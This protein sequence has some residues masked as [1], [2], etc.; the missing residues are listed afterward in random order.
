MKLLHLSAIG[1][2]D[3]ILA[4]GILP[5]KISLES[6]LWAF[7]DAGLNGD[8]CVYTWDSEQGQSTDKYIR[9]MIYCK[10]FIHPRNNFGLE[11]YEKLKEQGIHSFNTNEQ[12]L[13]YRQFGTQLYGDVSVFDLYEIEIEEDNEMLLRR[14]FIH[15]QLRDESPYD[16]C[17][18]LNEK[19]SHNDKVLRISGS[20]IPPDMLK[21]VTS[22]KTR[23][24]KDDTI[25]ISYSKFI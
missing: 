18:M 22:I 9:D 6:H 2:R 23:K 20:T 4:N 5:S 8:E 21:L 25:G 1:N 7:Q 24:Y 10:L 14:E 3:S 13:D 16:S 15:G 17:H 11:H 19:Y 12:K